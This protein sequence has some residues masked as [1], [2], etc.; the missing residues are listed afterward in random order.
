MGHAGSITFV[1][2]LDY[3]D[4]SVLSYIVSLMLDFEN[5]MSKCGCDS[6]VKSRAKISSVK[7]SI[8]LT[9]FRVKLSLSLNI[10]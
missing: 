9:S 6:D 2:G 10:G 8:L 4:V 1:V 3:D 5:I 7:C